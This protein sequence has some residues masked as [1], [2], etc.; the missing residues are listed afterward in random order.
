MWRWTHNN[1]YRDEDGWMES[2]STGQ[3]K[4]HSSSCA[5]S[6]GLSPCVC[7]SLHPHSFEADDVDHH[8][9]RERE[10]EKRWWRWSGRTYIVHK[11]HHN[12]SFV[13]SRSKW[14]AYY[15]LQDKTESLVLRN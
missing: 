14:S 3:T 8:D 13:N 11:G 7:L 2:A 12:H 6:V 9:L 10:S 1:K 5:A 15:E 4:A